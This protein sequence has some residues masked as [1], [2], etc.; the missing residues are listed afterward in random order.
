MEGSYYLD[1]RERPVNEVFYYYT[2]P[3][4]LSLTLTSLSLSLSLLKFTHEYFIE[5]C[6]LFLLS[7]FN[8]PQK[9]IEQN[10]MLGLLRPDLK[11]RFLYYVSDLPLSVGT[12]LARKMAAWEGIPPLYAITR[13]LIDKVITPW[14]RVRPISTTP[15]P[16]RSA[17][18]DSRPPRQNGWDAVRHCVSSTH[19]LHKGHRNPVALWCPHPSKLPKGASSIMDSSNRAPSYTA[20]DDGEPVKESKVFKRA[21]GAEAEAVGDSVIKDGSESP[22]NARK[23]V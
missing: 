19:T 11:S 2:I 1:V 6:H 5:L 10:L 16:N 18:T 22:D 8:L 14:D 15:G 3:I 9:C 17:R 7:N 21:R 4:T 20:S 12:S 23:D 13:A